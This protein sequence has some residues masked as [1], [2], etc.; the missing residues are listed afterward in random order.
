MR[1]G[2]IR[3]FAG[4]ATLL[5]VG[6]ATA[7]GDG[8]TPAASDGATDGPTAPTN[9]PRSGSGEDDATGGD[10]ATKSDASTPPGCAPAAAGAA[11][12]DPFR[13]A[14]TTTDLADDA[15]GAYQV[16]VLYVEPSDRTPAVR[17]DEE[18][19]I[20]RSVTAF[21]AWLA[22]RLG[23]AKLR[24]DTCGGV[25]D[26]THVKLAAP[27]TE[28][29]MA[30]GTTLAPNGPAFLRDRLEKELAKTFADP[31][32]LYLV[33]YDGLA[34]GHC[35]GG[36]L[37]PSLVGRVS[38][39]YTGGIFSASF[40]TQAASAGSSQV[41]VY[42]PPAAGLAAAPFAG[43]LGSE[44]VSVT[45]VSGTTVTLA[46][47]LAAPHALGE[48][49]VAST[50]PPDCRDNPF[51]S[52]GSA[53]G[54]TDYSGAHELMHALGIVSSAAKYHSATA[55]PG[56]LS[57]ASAG[58]TNDL[59]YQ[60]TQAWTCAVGIHASPQASPC[61]LDPAHENYVALPVGSA[62]I[63]L[64]KSVFLDPLPAGAVTPPGW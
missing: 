62:A 54:Y 35:G 4:L 20:R 21:E 42:D 60:G 16:H 58:G 49:L 52:N 57:E 40:L 32:K 45:A 46:S 17:L 15:P 38:A 19:S 50:R 44:S 28:A 51:S 18:G 7:C 12:D 33:Y 39:L 56:H 47:P 61:V 53:L 26:V 64:T 8:A 23:G 59:M 36:P 34:F 6:V 24:F 63:D 37:P 11:G 1:S 3:R 48:V 9:P 31:K 41:T 30:Q 25:L 2:T 29:A 55:A 13:R 14:R 22:S 5:A 10:G 27:F 43:K